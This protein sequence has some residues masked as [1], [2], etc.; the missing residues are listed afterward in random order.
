MNSKMLSAVFLVLIACNL[1][2]KG[3]CLSCKFLE[4]RNETATSKKTEL[5]E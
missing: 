5:I 1:I 3:K 4:Q 2:C